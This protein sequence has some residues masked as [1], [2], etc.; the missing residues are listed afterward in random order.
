MERDGWLVS[1]DKFRAEVCT[2]LLPLRSSLC[3]SSHP[4]RVAYAPRCVVGCDWCAFDDNLQLHSQNGKRSKVLA[5]G[6]K[7]DMQKFQKTNQIRFSFVM[8]EFV[9]DPDSPHLRN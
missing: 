2:C 3:S 4:N 6:E 5:N 8:Q 7:V 1:N 9:P